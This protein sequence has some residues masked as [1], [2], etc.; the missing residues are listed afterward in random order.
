MT[1]GFKLFCALLAAGTA[2]LAYAQPG[3]WIVGEAAG[4]VTVTEDGRSRAVP[5]GTMIAPGATV[6]TGANSRAVVVKGKDFVTVSA[7]S[8]VRIPAAT[9]KRGLFE[10][11]QEWGNAVFQIEKQKRPHFGVQT[12]YLAAVVKGT[13]FSITVT[14]QGASLQVVEGAVEVSTLDGGAAELIRPGIVASVASN[15]RYRLT[16]QGKDVRQIDSPLRGTV[17]VEPI[18]AAGET[19]SEP[20]Q[21]TAEGDG[22]GAPSAA[23]ELSDAQFIGGP[24]GSDPV[25]LG[26]VTGGLLA[27]NS[28]VQLATR[29]VAVTLLGRDTAALGAVSLTSTSGSNGNANG[30]ANVG[31]SSGTGVGTGLAPGAGNPASTPGNAN[32]DVSPGGNLDG[33]LK[34]LRPGSGSGP[35]FKP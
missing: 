3:D 30:Q 32:A 19:T 28:A 13:T 1:R 8:R 23:P 14:T 15:D 29:N 25:D 2:P 10:V 11:V 20:N 26:R 16:V 9:E 31:G 24:I 21:L 33:A 27:G 5:R 18:A 7:N 6:S 34:A 12:P 22:S 4:T 17:A 35:G